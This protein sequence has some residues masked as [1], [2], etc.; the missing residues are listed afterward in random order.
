MVFLCVCFPGPTPSSDYG[1]TTL[2]PNAAGTTFTCTTATPSTPPSSLLSGTPRSLCVDRL[3]WSH[4]CFLSI[5]NIA[6][7]L[8]F[9]AW[10][11][12]RHHFSHMI[13]NLSIE[14]QI[15]DVFFFY[16]ARWNSIKRRDLQTSEPNRFLFHQKKTLLHFRT[17]WHSTT[18]QLPSKTSIKESKS[19]LNLTFVVLFQWSNCSR[20]LW[21]RDSPRGGVSVRLRPA[22]LLQW[23]CL[24]PDRLQHFLQVR[25]ARH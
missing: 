24:Q 17:A 21:K 10:K 20:A 16:S 11:S 14:T 4:I 8:V 9:W 15:K 18:C 1:S 19:V 13:F 5:S 22:A 6:K 12:L 2:P 25:E 7:Y 23:R 3:S